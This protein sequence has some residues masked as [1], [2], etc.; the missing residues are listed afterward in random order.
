MDTVLRPAGE[1][2]GLILPVQVLR[3]RGRDDHGPL[4]RDGVEGA[5]CELDAGEAGA[6]ELPARPVWRLWASGE[7][8]AAAAGQEEQQPDHEHHRRHRE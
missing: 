8:A 6:G 7:Q 3:V 4:R 1:A 5:E 2:E